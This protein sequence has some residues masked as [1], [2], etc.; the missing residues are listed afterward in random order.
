M[1][2]YKHLETK[3]KGTSYPPIT[4]LVQV[5]APPAVTGWIFSGVS[6]RRLKLFTMMTICM[7]DTEGEEL[8]EIT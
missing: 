7:V 8:Y 2:K 4:E 6:H 5:V 3:K 1:F